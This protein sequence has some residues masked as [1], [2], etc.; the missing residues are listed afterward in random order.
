MNHSQEG[1]FQNSKLCQAPSL[2]SR[3]KGACYHMAKTIQNYLKK[4]LFAYLFVFLYMWIESVVTT[5]KN[6]NTHFVFDLTQKN[7]YLTS[8]ES[9]T[10]CQF[11][12]PSYTR[13]FQGCV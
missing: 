9:Y 10:V 3:Y 1:D 7:L 6:Y 11:Q 4:L 12:V 2:F 5:D 13:Y 8:F